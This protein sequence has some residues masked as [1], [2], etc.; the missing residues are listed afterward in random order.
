MARPVLPETLREDIRCSNN[1]KRN[2]TFVRKKICL[3]RNGLLA[4]KFQLLGVVI[5]MYH[6]LTQTCD[7]RILP[8]N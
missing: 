1:L 4:L 5:T 7:V 6:S 8:E 2:R 3:L